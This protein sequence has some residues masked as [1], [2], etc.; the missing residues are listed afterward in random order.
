MRA[1]RVI[2]FYNRDLPKQYGP[3][4]CVDIIDTEGTKTGLLLP[5][6]IKKST[7]APSLIEAAL[8]YARSAGFDRFATLQAEIEIRK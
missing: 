6:H 3:A 7:S 4:W 2:I 5:K 8:M 1:A